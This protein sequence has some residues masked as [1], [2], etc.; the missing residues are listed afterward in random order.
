MFGL[1]DAIASFSD[2]TTVL[3][4]LLVAVLL[5]LRHAIDPD[6]LVAVTTLTAS[7]TGPGARRAGSLG[8]A[9][10]LGH[11]TTLF[12]LG[13][14]II[15]YR[16]YLPEAAQRLA[17]TAIGLLIVGLAIWLL[18]RWRRGVFHAHLHE[19]DG[20][21]HLHVHTHRQLDEHAHG[22]RPTIRTP[23]QAY[24]IGLVHGIGGSAGVGILL[25][26]TIGS[27]ALGLVALA[28]F[29]A[30]TAVSMA[31]VSTGFGLT[32]A[33]SPV[34]SSFAVLAP[35]L[36]VVSMAFGIW[37]VLGALALAPYYF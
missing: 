24:G 30:F 25:L 36:G 12:L 23:L 4:V 6:H 21:P 28:L 20:A 26:S 10:G 37:Y 35:P 15:L 1:D 19:H 5:G 27:H 29:A 16:A 34:R 14:P 32:L 9:W 18:V 22:H 7:G 13:V 3:V 11:A 2:G 17:E 8:L 31:L 33:S